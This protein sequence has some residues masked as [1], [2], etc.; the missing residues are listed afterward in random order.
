MSPTSEWLLAQIESKLEAMIVADRDGIIQE[1]N[2]AA[3][4]IFGY[5]AT[6]AIGRTLDLVV[7]E[8]ER[9]D[10]WRNYRRVIA[11]NI[12]NY[13]PDHILDVEG[14]RKDGSRVPLD[15][16][17]EP[18]RDASGHITAITAHLREAANAIP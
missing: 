17:L 8:E 13:T 2:S 16:M 18:T 9:A 15:A 4:R 7:P 5:S 14:V 6:E 1:W 12:I 11:T 3:E 10:H